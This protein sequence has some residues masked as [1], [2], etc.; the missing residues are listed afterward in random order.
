MIFK[1]YVKRYY[2]K[3]DE[4]VVVNPIYINELIELGIK[5]EKINLNIQVHYILVL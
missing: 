3:A 2:K 1:S 5:R 4:I